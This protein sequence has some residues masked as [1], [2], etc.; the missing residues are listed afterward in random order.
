MKNFLAFPLVALLISLFV[1]SAE[2]SEV[3]WSIGQTDQTSADLALGTKSPNTTYA[4]AF[5]VDPLFVVGKSTA[6][7]D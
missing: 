7:H 2:A 6:A 4:K 5:P 1:I 3:L